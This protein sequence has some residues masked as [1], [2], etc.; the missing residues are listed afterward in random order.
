[1]MLIFS[2]EANPLELYR[3]TEVRTKKW[4]QG[5]NHN[6]KYDR[7]F[8]KAFKASTRNHKSNFRANYS[9]IIVTEYSIF[10]LN[11]INNF[12]IYI[13]IYFLC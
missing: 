6:A 2:R 7:F 3:Y 5:D 8:S 11:F 1:M 4:F 12:N 10:A 13:Y 9:I